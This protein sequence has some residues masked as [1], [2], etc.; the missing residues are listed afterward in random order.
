[1]PNTHAHFLNVGDGDCSVVELPDGRLMM[2]DIRNGRIDNSHN[3][4]FTNP[5]HYLKNLTN[6]R[7]IY[8]YIQTH[9]DMDHMD[10]LSDLIQDFNII[11][12]WDA[13]NTKPKPDEFIVFREEDWDAYEHLDQSASRTIN[14]LRQ[15]DTI[16][17]D[18]G[19]YVYDIY[20]LSPTQEILDQA[21]NSASS[22]NQA[23]YLT[24]LQ[25]SGFKL[26][27]GGDLTTEIWNNI[28][29]WIN[30]NNEASTLLSNI[31]VF[32]AS[33]HGRESGYCGKSLLFFMNPRVIIT[34]YSVPADESAN[35]HYDAYVQYDTQ[36]RRI[37]DINQQN[38]FAWYNSENNN[39]NVEY[40]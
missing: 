38:I 24:L 27:F 37:F 35:H 16:V 30:K 10:G 33:H 1:M 23:S 20:P 8:R 32:K 11:N 22:W 14:P 18:S 3:P 40:I 7:N 36:N 12:A 15:T 25:Y 2:V 13:E 28:V 21:N 9:P 29:E 34:D 6:N 4:N 39:Y 17:A 26:L 19:P 31:T 5:I